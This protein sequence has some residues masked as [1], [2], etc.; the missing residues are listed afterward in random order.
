M[1][2]KLAAILA[3]DVVGYSKLMAADE[4][5][6]LAALKAHRKDLFNPETERHGGRI[7]KLM[8]D[9]VLVEFPSVVDAVEC[10]IAIQQALIRDDSQIKLRIGVNLGDVIIEGDDIYGD[11]VNL[12]ARLEALAN[13]GGVCISD[14]VY[15]SV[16]SKLSAR[17]ED[18][19]K[20]ELKNFP[21][22]IRTYRISDIAAEPLVPAAGQPSSQDKPSIAV[23]AFNNM[24]G[25]PEQ[26]YFSDGISEDI[27]TELSRFQELFVIARNSSFSYKGKSTKVQEIGKDLGATYI[28]EGSVRKSGKRLRI[29]VQLIEAATGN[30]IWAERYDRE[31]EDM[32]ELQD[33]IT[34]TI[35]TVLP[36]RLQGALVAYSRKKPSESLSAYEC[37]LRAQQLYDH[38]SSNAREALEQLATATRID[39][40]FAQAFA[41]TAYV[42]AYSVFT[43]SPIGNDPTIAA[44]KYIQRALT[45][46]EGDH[47]VH[48]MACEVFMVCGEHDLAQIHSD[49]ALALNP[50]EIFALLEKGVL[51]NYSGK[52]KEA[53]EHLIKAL[54]H[55]PLAPDY[56]FEALAEANYMLGNYEEAIRIYKRWRDPPVH[57]YSHLAA[58]YAQLGQMKESRQ[59]AA[60]FEDGRPKDSDFT[61]YAKA[62]ARLCKRPEDAEHWL[63]GYRKAGLIG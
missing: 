24:S 16:H 3:A 53:V 12:A 17:F 23:L 19:G 38:T 21:E 29:S 43:L 42:H 10:A 52:S 62:H 30:H 25:D 61:F 28:V 37:F 46:G 50:N 2:R 51:L 44:R 56:Q 40:N 7:V 63:E 18:M 32:F 57:M 22:P 5:G 33:E 49:K 15:Q 4:A 60:L 31:L 47:Y 45:L 13:V 59:A 34:Q 55:D 20:Q 27:I 39:P 8:G 14:I 36:L 54:A 58:C 9:G 1:E 48:A 11:G 41:L 35:V 26:E 6:T